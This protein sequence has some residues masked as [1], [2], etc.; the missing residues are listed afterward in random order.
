MKPSRPRRDEEEITQQIRVGRE[1]IDAAV[2]KTAEA[3]KRLQSSIPPEA[4]NADMCT[5][6]EP[7][8]STDDD[9]DTQR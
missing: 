2:G 8:A 4:P 1:A 6:E 7:D 9:E 5:E 3:L